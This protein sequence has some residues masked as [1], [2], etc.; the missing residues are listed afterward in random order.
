M[1]KRILT[2]TKMHSV[3]GSRWK[4]MIEDDDLGNSN[5]TVT[6]DDLLQIISMFY[7]QQDAEEP[8]PTC[9]YFGDLLG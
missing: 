6:E 5:I 4:I 8:C 9:G 2:L 1:S 3:S 7:D